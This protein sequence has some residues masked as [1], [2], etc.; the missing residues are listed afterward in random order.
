MHEP[1][2]RR[3]F[4]AAP[5]YR[6]ALRYLPYESVVWIPG[7]DDETCALAFKWIN[8]VRPHGRRGDESLQR[9]LFFYIPSD[10]RMDLLMFFS[11]SI[12][13]SDELHSE[14]SSKAHCYHRNAT[15]LGSQRLLISIWAIR[16]NIHEIQYNIHIRIV[17]MFLSEM[18]TRTTRAVVLRL[19]FK[20][21]WR[22][23][24]CRLDSIIGHQIE[25]HVVS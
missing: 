20:V 5:L 10:K 14:L 7:I 1:A 23:A 4:D 18:A 3:A 16:E 25:N 6:W 21:M 24:F 15:A 11:H 8:N 12:Y 9:V 13:L 19:W 22:D 2:F 17:W